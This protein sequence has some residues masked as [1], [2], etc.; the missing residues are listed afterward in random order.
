MSISIKNDY[1]IDPNS[2][3]VIIT[4]GSGK[5]ATKSRVAPQQIGTLGQGDINI[6]LEHPNEDAAAGETKDEGAK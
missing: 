4:S 2:P 5:N 1:P 3:S 6:T